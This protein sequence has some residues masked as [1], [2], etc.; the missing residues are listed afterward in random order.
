LRLHQ[1]PAGRAAARPLAER[2]GAVALP[3]P[4]AGTFPCRSGAAA[5][6]RAGIGKE[7][8]AVIASPRAPTAIDR[9]KKMGADAYP[10]LTRW[11]ACQPRIQDYLAQ[12]GA[13]VAEPCR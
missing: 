5:S 7:A 2:V 4:F 8:E 3:D 12:T 13:F 1:A 10:W 6:L 9:P 11:L